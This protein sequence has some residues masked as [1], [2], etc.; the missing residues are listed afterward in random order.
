M[1]PVLA[2]PQLVEGWVFVQPSLRRKERNESDSCTF[3]NA[4][5]LLSFGLE[6]VLFEKTILKM[7][8]Q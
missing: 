4:E 2:Y 3:S 5:L 1:D 7:I 8:Q 6:M